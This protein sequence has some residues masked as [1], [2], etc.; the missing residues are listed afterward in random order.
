MKQSAF[1]E[2]EF[3]EFVASFDLEL[4]LLIIQCILEDFYMNDLLSGDFTIEKAKL[5]RMLITKVLEKRCFLL[6]NWKSNKYRNIED[7]P[8]DEREMKKSIKTLGLFWDPHSDSF[9]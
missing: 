6:R 3:L 4:I 9:T 2:K 5:K 7:I 1:D 8:E